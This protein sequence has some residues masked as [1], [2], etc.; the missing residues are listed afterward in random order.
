MKLKRLSEMTLED[1][2]NFPEPR[3]LTPEERAEVLRLA[4][5]SFTAADL[6]QFADVDEGVPLEEFIAD[7]EARAREYHR[8]KPDE[9][10]QA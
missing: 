6:A 2:K 9:Q 1:M 5:E 4:R 7:L 8:T 3:D 10:A